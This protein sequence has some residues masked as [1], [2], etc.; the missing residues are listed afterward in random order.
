MITISPTPSL[1]NPSIVD[2]QLAKILNNTASAL[3]QIGLESRRKDDV[4]AYLSDEAYLEAH[5]ERRPVVVIDNF[6]H[7]AQDNA[8][9]YDKFAEW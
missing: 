5:P 1:T 9:I 2:S 4:D 6:L 8:L 3:K 7:K